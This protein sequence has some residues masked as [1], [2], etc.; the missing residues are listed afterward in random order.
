MHSANKLFLNANKTQTI[1]FSIRN[2]DVEA[3]VESVK[4]LGYI[5]IRNC[6]G[7]LTRISPVNFLNR[8]RK[9]C[10]V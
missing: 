1:V 6:D 9:K 3:T 2:G 7:I 10:P 5:W 8:D 4:F